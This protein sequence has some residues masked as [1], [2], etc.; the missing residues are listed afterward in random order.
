MDKTTKQLLSDLV[1]AGK[2][3][4]EISRKTKVAQATLSRILTGVNKTEYSRVHGQILE[5]Y[6]TVLPS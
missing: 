2:S 3:Q 6:R 5:Y 4:H 1:A